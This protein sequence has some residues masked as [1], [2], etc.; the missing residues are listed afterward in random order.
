M[1]VSGRVLLRLEQRV[2]VPERA[3]DEVVGRHLCEAA[4]SSEFNLCVCVYVFFHHDVHHSPHLQEDLP[5]LC[6]HLHQRVQ[7]ATVRGHP[8]GLKVVRFKF[9]LFPATT[10][11][12]HKLLRGEALLLLSPQSIS[13]LY[14]R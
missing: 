4:Q 10:E 13:N 8:Q 12:Q 5:K 2:E 14:N 9:L 1:R 6:S 3:L 7:V 11:T